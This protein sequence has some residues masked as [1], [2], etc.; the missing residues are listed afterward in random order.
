MLL[1]ELSKRL[2]VPKHRVAYAVG[3]LFDADDL[4]HVVT[5]S[6][7]EAVD[8][9]E[10]QARE[11]IM[12]FADKDGADLSAAVDG[13]ADLRVRVA[14]LEGEV[15]GLRVEVRMLRELLDEKDRRIE[16]L[17]EDKRRLQEERPVPFW[18]RW[19]PSGGSV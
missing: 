1:S 19:L 2:D 3:K 5:G 7:H 17:G 8:L 14:E 11:V 9:S 12:F 16:E 18:R 13:D 10:A 4:G 15:N 6:G